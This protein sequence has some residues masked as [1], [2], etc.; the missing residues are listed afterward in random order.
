MGLLYD[1][2]LSDFDRCAWR[3]GL[4]SDEALLDVENSMKE[5]N[6]VVLQLVDID[7]YGEDLWGLI[8]GDDWLRWWHAFLLQ[9]EAKC[10]AR[11]KGEFSGAKKGWAA[12][13]TWLD[14]FMPLYIEGCY[15]ARH[16]RVR[17][18]KQIVVGISNDS[19]LSEES[20][21]AWL[22]WASAFES[23]M[24]DMITELVFAQTEENQEAS[25]QELEAAAGVEGA[26]TLDKLR[27]I[28]SGGKEDDEGGGSGPDK[29]ESY[30]S[31]FR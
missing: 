18:V 20:R 15:I 23:K 14:I 30:N 19:R 2:D 17:E 28:A 13:K 9:Y 8:T 21:E 10:N 25:A 5:A 27:R 12:I 24:N 3:C 4:K 22:Q 31:P 16:I 11:W 7:K 29:G 1:Y 6:D 26:S